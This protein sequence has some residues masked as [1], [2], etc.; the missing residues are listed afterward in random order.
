M[1]D[2]FFSSGTGHSLMVLSLVIGI[3]LLIGKLKIKGISLGTVCVLWTGILV[4]ALGVKADSLFLHFIKELG[5]I[6]FVFSIGLQ[7]GPAF[8]SSLRKEGLKLNLLAALL[9]FLAFGIVLVLYATTENDLASLVGSLTGAF[10]NTPGLGTAQQTYYDTVYGTF[11]EEVSHPQVSAQI[12]DAFAV[13]YPVGILVLTGVIA[14]LRGLFRVDLKAEKDRIERED[15]ASRKIVTRTFE[16]VNPAIVGRKFSDIVRLFGSTFIAT[17][18]NRGAQ[19]ISPADDPVLEKGDLI[20]AD[21]EQKDE[22]DVCIIFGKMT[23]APEEEAAVLRGNVVNRLVVVTKHNL[24][25]KHI[26]E[27]NVTDQFRVTV[28]RVV[29]SGVNLVARGD[30][31]LQLGDT[32]KVIGT[33][34]DI[35]RFAEFVGNSSVSLEKPNLMPIFLGIALGLILG[36]LPIRFPGMGVGAR[37]GMAGGTLIAAILIGHFGPRW[38]I[39]TYTTASANKMIREVGLALLLGTVGLGAGRSFPAAFSADG[40]TWILYAALLVGVPAL[41][42]GILARKAFHLNFYQICG[43]LSGAG[44]ATPVL[45]FTR[46]AYGTDHV[47]VSYAA[48]Y[49]L[50]MFLQVLIAQALVLVAIG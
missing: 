15:G 38:K 17:G 22:R 46:E 7:V 48:V 32:L 37:L 35:A 26:N 41:V 5:L 47:S 1:H 23:G 11:L 8:F 18:L 36:A 3:G 25:G 24:N 9:I 43:L 28:T 42:T 34:E 6:L 31:R 16:A 49:P 29:R 2:L 19:T 14:L 40:W 21:L 20:V 30:L 27:L 50:S 13:A 44:T 39:T 33:Q 12:T 10:T 4:S 45:D